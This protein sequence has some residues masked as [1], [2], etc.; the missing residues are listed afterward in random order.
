M[1][2]VSLNSSLPSASV[3]FT[4]KNICAANIAY[5]LSSD[6]FQCSSQVSFKGRNECINKSA[7]SPLKLEVLPGVSQEFISMVTDEIS[8]FP[9]EWLHKFKDKGFKIIIAPTFKE[10]YASQNVF[11]PTIEFFEKKN[12]LGTL[13]VTYTEGEFGKNF[14]VFA[15]KPPYS[16]KFVDAIVPHELSHGVVSV[17][18]LDK[19]EKV[20]KLIKNDI[21]LIIKQNKLHK[22]TPQER[23]LISHYFFSKTAYLPLDEIIA[24]VYAW[25]KSKGCYGSGLV[26]GVQNPNLMKELFPSLSEY[27][28]SL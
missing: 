13:G 17:T 28:N 27:L 24:D 21:D 12:P 4:K 19:N 11:D 8:A 20:L 9:K 18:K 25:N 6:F 23:K 10:A 1:L 14:F 3:K 15:D 16:N 26:L 22:L 5:K 2:K 7:D